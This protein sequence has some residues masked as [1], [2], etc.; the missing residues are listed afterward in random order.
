MLKQSTK[1]HACITNSFIY[2]VFFYFFA[3]IKA[4]DCFQTC[5]KIRPF[6]IIILNYTT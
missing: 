6:T 3:F 5:Y 2:Q 4:F 1:A